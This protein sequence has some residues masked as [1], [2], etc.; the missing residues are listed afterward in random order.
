MRKAIL[1]KKPVILCV[2]DEVMVL[3]SLKREIKEKF[4]DR[5]LYEM[6]ETADD[7]LEIIAELQEDNAGIIMIISD[8]LMPGMKGDEFLIYVHD[9]YPNI[10]KILLTGQANDEAVSR[11]RQ[12]ANLHRCLHKPWNKKELIETIESGV[13]HE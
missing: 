9:K 6:A 1:V 2:D 11:A 3:E 13:S 4:A 5:F 12:L 10:I 8:W 7:A